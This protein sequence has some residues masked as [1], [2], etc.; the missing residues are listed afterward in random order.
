MNR[1]TRADDADV[2]VGRPVPYK[3]FPIDSTVSM[4]LYAWHGQ[5]NA[6]MLKSGEFI[7]LQPMG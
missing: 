3:E 7:H 6:M 5:T 1:L 4:L 2:T